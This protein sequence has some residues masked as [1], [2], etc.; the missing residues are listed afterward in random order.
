MTLLA[1]LQS[2]TEGSR[3][4]DDEIW[5]A[6]VPE[7]VKYEHVSAP[8]YTTSLDAAV[9]LVPEGC[10]WILSR[11]TLLTEMRIGYTAVIE[12]LAGTG[13]SDDP[14][15]F[16]GKSE[17]AGST[18]ALALCIAIIKAQEAREAA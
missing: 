11:I 1:Q 6:M 4:L 10:D 9:S 13:D 16:E 2:A 14:Y 7:A 12:G 3:K 5:R 18:P 15:R 17:A 8:R